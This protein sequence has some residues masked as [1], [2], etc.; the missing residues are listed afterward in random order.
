MNSI[1]R[2]VALELKSVGE[3]LIF[4][5]L[6]SLK[7]INEATKIMK[8]NTTNEIKAYQIYQKVVD[9]N[10]HLKNDFKI[11]QWNYIENIII[12][13]LYVMIAKGNL[14]LEERIV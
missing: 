12:E 5:Y 2:G 6:D 11:N 4:S 14:I 8:E 1:S 7:G 13:K 3:N 10:I 9:F